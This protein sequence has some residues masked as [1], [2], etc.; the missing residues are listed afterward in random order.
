MYAQSLSPRWDRE[1]DSANGHGLDLVEARLDRGRVALRV[2]AL[3]TRYGAIEAL[4]GVSSST[5]AR[6]RSSVC[7]GLTARARPH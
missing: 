4:A 7:S 6:A 2:E 5:C 1:V 3:S